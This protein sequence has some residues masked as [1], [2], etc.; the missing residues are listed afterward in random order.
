MTYPRKK[1]IDSKGGRNRGRAWYAKNAEKLR[2]KR[3]NSYEKKQAG[4]GKITKQS[5]MKKTME[6]ERKQ[7]IKPI[8]SVTKE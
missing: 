8:L 2:E 5:L 3:R 1:E 4:L 7:Q 6:T